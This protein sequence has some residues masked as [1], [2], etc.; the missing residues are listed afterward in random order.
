VA[1]ADLSSLPLYTTP[2]LDGLEFLSWARW[3]A[4]GDFHWP[5]DP[6]HS[7]L[8]PYL[9][10]GWLRLGGVG[11]ARVAQCVGGALL[12]C[13]VAI[14][15]A[16]HA[17]AR[18]GRAA[19]VL[20]ALYG[21]LVWIET[22]ILA[23][24]LMLV[25]VSAALVA[26]TSGKPDRRAGAWTGL[27][28]GLA[29]AARPSAI[30]ILAALALSLSSRSAGRRRSAAALALATA[31]AAAV[32][33]LPVVA[34]SR[35]AHGLVPG[36]AFGGYAFYLGNRA[37]SSGLPEDRPGG[38]WDLRRHA[39]E[40]AGVRGVAARDRAYVST[41]LGE[42]I[43]APGEAAARFGRKALWAL[44]NE[45]IRDTHSYWF[46]RARSRLL[47]VLPG[48]AL[49]VALAVAALFARPRGHWPA[50]HAW[51]AGLFVLTCVAVMVG[52][53]YRLPVVP[54]LA[55]FAGQGAAWLVVSLRER[56]GRGFAAL[57]A[58]TGVALLV[59]IP[60][61]PA[62]RNGAEEWHLSGASLESEGQFE[63]AEGSYRESIARDSGSAPAWIGL[64]RAALRR[65]D[66][67]SASAAFRTAVQRQPDDHRA[68][69]HLGLAQRLAGEVEAA[70][71]SFARATDLAPDDWRPRLDSARLL[72][73]LGR[74]GPAEAAFREVLARQPREV[75]ALLGVARCAGARGDPR[76]GLESAER[77]AI[78]A[79]GNGTAWLLVALLG[80]EA[81]DWDRVEPALARARL[82]L[83]LE[84]EPTIEAIARRLRALRG[85]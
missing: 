48:F 36:Q 49:L 54:S 41:A 60:R 3:I 40:A 51:S 38:S 6:S 9:L 75:E 84:A 77:A 79:P 71:D 34:A 74:V 85:P 25:L 64:G 4:A 82:G 73:E 59:H 76:A 5:E 28:V 44:S 14:L 12:C 80:L 20:L 61:H 50:L 32:W 23:E 47:S 72:L 30:V 33:L 67:E 1:L 13:L 83:G 68:R 21:P 10:A 69:H 11:L 22:S 16:R 19:G 2:Q 81:G 29:A 7:P 8:Y 53:R 46:F 62:S 63:E 27:W 70:L 35:A 45:E 24:P 65:G 66:L 78:L 58:V 18:A 57:L 31:V 55:V 39:M 26:W 37:V 52:T 15:A 17:G 43:A 42:M 56:S